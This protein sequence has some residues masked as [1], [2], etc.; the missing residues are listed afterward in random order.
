MR[1]ITWLFLAKE[2]MFVLYDTE[3]SQAHGIVK[4]CMC[5]CGYVL[6]CVTL[7][8]LLPHQYFIVTWTQQNNNKLPNSSTHYTFYVLHCTLRAD[9][10]FV[11]CFSV[12]TNTDE[13]F[14]IVII[15]MHYLLTH[16]TYR[17]TRFTQSRNKL[18]K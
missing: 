11:F 6:P 13:T 7:Q 12:T 10:L 2:N 18:F 16:I 17:K 9:N 14:K 4:E 3:F 15:I 8:V 5:V 1:G